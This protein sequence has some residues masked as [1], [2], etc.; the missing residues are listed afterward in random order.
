MTIE[1]NL[2]LAYLRT[3]K[4]QNAFFARV[5]KKDRDFFREQLAV[6]DMGLEDRMSQPV[7]LLDFGQ[8]R[9]GQ[10]DGTGQPDA[11]KVAGQLVLGHFGSI[12]GV[13]VEHR[14]AFFLSPP[15]LGRDG[16]LLRGSGVPPSRSSS[17]PAHGAGGSGR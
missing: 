6:L 10:G 17:S 2:S 12:Q 8:A 13:T 5:G 14:V 16:R 15:R 7:G 4:N 11:V 9:Q 1:E 3:A